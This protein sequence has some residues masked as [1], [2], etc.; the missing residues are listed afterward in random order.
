[1][2]ILNRHMAPERYAYRSPTRRGATACRVWLR[3]P[4]FKMLMPGLHRPS[5]CAHWHQRL[6][7][8]PAGWAGER[9]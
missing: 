4:L 9:P 5:G 3:V 7:N 2:R 8:H 6:A 1:M